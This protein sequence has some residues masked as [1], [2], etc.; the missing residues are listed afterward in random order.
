M[1]ALIF[2]LFLCRNSHAQSTGYIHLGAK[3]TSDVYVKCFMSSP[4]KWKLISKLKD[5]P[6]LHQKMATVEGF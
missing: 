2:Q 1:F 6:P 4:L 5:K 3:S